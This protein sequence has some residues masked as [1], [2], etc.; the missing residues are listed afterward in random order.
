MVKSTPSKSIAVARLV[1]QA[2]VEPNGATATR[3]QS[4]NLKSNGSK[5]IS[6]EKAAFEQ[7]LEEAS[8]L[9]KR[10]NKKLEYLLLLVLIFC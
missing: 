7:L 2:N 10:S 9:Y 8:V 6:V 5:K 3:P 1:G 4:S